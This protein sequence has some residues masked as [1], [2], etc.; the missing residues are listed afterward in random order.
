MTKLL[1]SGVSVAFML[2]LASCAPS[3]EEAAARRGDAGTEPVTTALMAAPDGHPAELAATRG[4]HE[5]HFRGLAFDDHLPYGAPA[6]LDAP[7]DDRVT[8]CQLS[9][10]GEQAFF[11]SRFVGGPALGLSALR[12]SLRSAIN[13][14]LGA[15]QYSG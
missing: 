15:A 1:L 5:L 11:V 8:V 3:F 14:A 9:D 2:V 6:E 12:T 10:D 13:K 4:P 7:A